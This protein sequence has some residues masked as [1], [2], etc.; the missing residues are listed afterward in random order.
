MSKCFWQLVDFPK[1][2]VVL[3]SCYRHSAPPNQLGFPVISL[4]PFSTFCSFS[5]RLFSFFSNLLVLLLFYRTLYDDLES[6]MAQDT[7][8]AYESIFLQTIAVLSLRKTLAST[9]LYVWPWHC[10]PFF[11]ICVYMWIV[12]FSSLTASFQRRRYASYT[13]RDPSA[14]ASCMIPCTE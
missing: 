9:I 4:L 2:L 7:Q 14:V 11:G 13:P 8:M 6:S 3:G 10:Q 5:Q 1:G 12:N